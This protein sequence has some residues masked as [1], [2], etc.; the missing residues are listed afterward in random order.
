MKFSAKTLLIALCAV[1]A[2]NFTSCGSA[3]S[4]ADTA[5]DQVEDAANSVEEG[6]SDALDNVTD[7]TNALVESIDAELDAASEDVFGNELSD[8]EVDSIL[9][10]DSE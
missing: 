6:A 7:E 8:E 3:E 9:K 5:K 4:A 2:I 10:E 1:I